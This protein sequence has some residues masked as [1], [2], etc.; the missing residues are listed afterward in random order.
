MASQEVNQIVTKKGY[1]FQ[2]KESYQQDKS[3]DT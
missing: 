1:H 2:Y 3:Q